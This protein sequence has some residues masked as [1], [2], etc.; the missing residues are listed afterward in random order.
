MNATG[1]SRQ[2]DRRDRRDVATAW[3]VGDGPRERPGA[4]DGVPVQ[5]T[6]VDDPDLDAIERDLAGVEAALDHL[7]DGRVPTD[8]ALDRS[9]MTAPAAD[10]ADRAGR[11]PD[12]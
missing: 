7:A 8:E 10:A 9:P 3:T 5:S 6:A 11:M 4:A 2:R 1:R 12:R